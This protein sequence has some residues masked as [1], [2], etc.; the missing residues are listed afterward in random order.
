MSTA[1]MAALVSGCGD[2]GGSDSSTRDAYV[3]NLLDTGGRV[4]ARPDGRTDVPVVDAGMPIDAEISRDASPGPSDAEL[5]PLVDLGL[6]PDAAEMMP[7][8]G[9]DLDDP[10]SEVGEDT[11]GDGLDDAWEQGA[12]DPGRLDWQVA[13]TDGDGTPDGLEDFDS[14][15]L[16]CLQEQAAGRVSSMTASN[17]PHPFLKDLLVEVDAMEDRLP[18]PVVFEQ[19][20]DVYE[21]IGRFEESDL[22]A[23]YVHFYADQLDLEPSLF[24]ANFGPRQNLLRTAGPRFD[25]TGQSFPVSRMVHLVFASGRTDLDTRAGEV[26]THQRDI[27]RTGVL[28]YSDTIEDLFPRCGLDDPPPIPYVTIDEAFAATIS[29]ELGHSLQLGHD[30]ELNGGVNEWNI[31]SVP[32]GCGATRR[33]S[34]G[35]DNDDI[36]WGSTEA[37]NAP[38]FSLDAARLIQLTNILSVDTSRLLDEDDGFEM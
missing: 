23:I 19:V 5:S 9:A 6:N 8:L 3:Y 24:D 16:S 37:D 21:A 31:M 30:T 7:D 20:R 33:R 12:G 32:A 15:G 29:H 4:Q 26:V 35:Q 28:I 13:D 22:E 25:G 27:E 36:R 1:V 18:G 34:H 17:R 14:D 2:S 11:D 38:R 10:L